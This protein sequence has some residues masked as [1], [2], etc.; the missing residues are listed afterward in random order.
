MDIDIGQGIGIFL[1][2]AFLIF[3]VPVVVL[4][5]WAIIRGMRRGARLW[6]ALLVASLVTAGTSGAVYVWWNWVGPFVFDL[7]N[8]AI[9]ILFFLAFLFIPIGGIAFGI[10]AVSQAGRPPLPLVE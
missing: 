2:A 6:R 3:A 10:W 7:R 9:G 5:G 8:D 1:I 4:L